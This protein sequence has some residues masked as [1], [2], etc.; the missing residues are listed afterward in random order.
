[1]V[2]KPGHGG[3]AAVRKA[4]IR[5]AVI[6]FGIGADYDQGRPCSVSLAA[7]VVGAV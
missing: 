4:V 6:A 5:R 7:S 2:V 1:M 3:G